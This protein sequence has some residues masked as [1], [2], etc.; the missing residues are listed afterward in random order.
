VN[1][2]EGLQPA[3]PSAMSCIF[4]SVFRKDHL[5]VRAEGR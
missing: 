3:S 4:S 5:D 1:E 2:E